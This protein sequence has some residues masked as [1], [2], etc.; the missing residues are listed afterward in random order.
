MVM[1]VRESK[2]RGGVGL[3]AGGLDTQEIRKSFFRLGFALAWGMPA[4][5]L[6]AGDSM[7]QARVPGG[8]GGD[9]DWGRG[10]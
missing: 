9:G 4:G 10:R 5:W 2:F 1:K 8:D 6:E 7:L 3:G